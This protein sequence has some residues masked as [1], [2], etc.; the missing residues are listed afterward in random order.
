LRHD[1]G[2]LFKTW[3]ILCLAVLTCV[4]SASLGALAVWMDLASVEGT[5]KQRA[6]S[7]QRNLAHRF[8]S[9]EAVLTALVGLHHASDDPRTGEFAALSRELLAAYPFIRMIAMSPAVAASDRRRFEHTM[10]SN[11]FLDFRITEQDEDG[12]L[13]RAGERPI[14]MPIQLFEPLEPEFTPLFGFDVFSEPTLAQTVENAIASGDV[15]ASDAVDIPHIGRG[16]LVFKAIYLGHSSPTSA[17]AR[18]SQ[19]SGLVTLF[20]EP[21]LFLRT[22]VESHEDF[23]FRLTT[24]PEGDHATGSPVFE[25]RRG[26][27]AGIS[28]FFEP[29]VSLM[30]I[31][32]HGRSFDLEVSSRPSGATISVWL[33]VLFIVLAAVACGFLILA[34]WNHRLGIARARESERILRQNQELFRDYA[35]IA[36]DWFWSTDKDLRFDYFSK[37]L[38]ASTGLQAGAVLGDALEEPDRSGRGV[39]EVH[40]HLAELEARRPFKDFRYR[41]VDGTGRSHWWRLSG[42]PVFTERGELMGYRGTGRNVT[43]EVE[44]QQSLQILK[45]QAELANRAKSEFIA[46]MSHELRTPLN[47]IIGFSEIMAHESFGPLGSTRYRD[48]A[49]DISESG[50]HLLALI[51]DILDLSKVESG[52]EELHEEYI[53][54][55]KLVD[56]L[57]TL[58]SH[59]AETGQIDLVTELD[60]GLPGL[61]ADKRKL[62]QILVNLLGNAIKF[63]RPGGR[64]ALKAGG[65]RTSGFAFQIIDT[66]IGIAVEDIPKALS[67]FR[68]IDSDLNRKYEGT[69]LGLPLAKTMTELH[70]G[71]LHLESELG[72]GTTVTVYLPATRIVGSPREASELPPEEVRNRQAEAVRAQFAREPVAQVA[73]DVERPG[74]KGRLVPTQADTAVVAAKRALI[75]P[76]GDTRYV[77]RG[78]TSRFREAMR[79]LAGERKRKLKSVAKRRH[80]D[81]G[82]R[83]SSLR[84]G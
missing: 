41:Y 24:K 39:D 74:L 31:R 57:M 38:A 83:R 73:A 12:G 46:N 53:E 35:E 37:P 6:D 55:P 43:P 14:T 64:V 49:N 23:S 61:I 47:A 51:N 16:I 60:R 15:V 2:R 32:A 62:K 36:S 5:F 84:P 19:L 40:R 20:L 34:L 52:N 58:M 29:F 1:G 67:K 68:Q 72:R 56:S 3:E 65:Q 76:N 78:K 44:A 25:N 30:P 54:V 70:G 69:G 8:G 11:G 10:R 81:K 13:T 63:T 75:A 77:R 79:S 9:T 82:D 33:V 18:R 48:Y 45:E 4:A 50:Q 27:P 80:G 7:I 22:F 17:E 66:G 71:R 28:R 42:K 59:H 26:T 21:G